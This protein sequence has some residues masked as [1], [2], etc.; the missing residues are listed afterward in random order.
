MIKTIDLFPELSNYL[1]G[2][3]KDLKED[4]WLKSTCIPGRTV[5]DIASHILDASCLR[6]LSAQRDGYIGENPDITSYSELIDFIQK[7]ANDWILA[8]KRLSPEILISLL[9]VMEKELYDFLKELDPYETAFWPVAWAGE[10]KSFVWFDIARDYTEK[11]H[12]QMQIRDAVH[13]TD[14]DIFEPKFVLPV[15]QTFMKALPFT[16]MDIKEKDNTLIVVR[17]TGKCGGNWFL[18]RNE[19]TWELSPGDRGQ[20]KAE[21]IIKDNIAWKLFTNSIRKNRNSYLRI[22]GDAKL[23]EKIADMVTVLS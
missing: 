2:L 17:I 4:D 22:E 20:V 7:L 15:Y 9:E 8:T 3:L 5:K 19:N 21:I 1:I 12:H 10:E 14:T 11:W 16:Y 6:R 13:K 23:G 18:Y